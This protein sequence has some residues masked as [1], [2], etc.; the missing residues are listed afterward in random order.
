MR[1]ADKDQLIK[2]LTKMEKN[3]LDPWIEE[4]SLYFSNIQFKSFFIGGQENLDT[5]ETLIEAL[6]VDNTRL[7][8]I[9]N[10][11]ETLVALLK[12][13]ETNDGQN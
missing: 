13:K 11:F 5:I 6:P 9:K 12:L 2:R 8:E 4:F 3:G 1:L 10:F 7:Y